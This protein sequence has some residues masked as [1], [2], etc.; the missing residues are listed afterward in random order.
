L[1]ERRHVP[2][3][4]FSES[5]AATSAITSLHHSEEKRQPWLPQKFSSPLDAV[6]KPYCCMS[7][8]QTSARLATTALLG[9]ASVRSAR[10]SAATTGET[11]ALAS[12]MTQ[13]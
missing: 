3:T 7:K 12:M 8:I 13:V 5:K 1:R 11:S 2:T 10:A 6:Q 9:L 4:R